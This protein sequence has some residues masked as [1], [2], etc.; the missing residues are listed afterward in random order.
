MST[1]RSPF[2]GWL[3]TS[4]FSAVLIVFHRFFTWIALG[5]VDLRFSLILVTNANAVQG[6]TTSVT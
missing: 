6:G 5:D 4:N 1:I 2:S 3:I